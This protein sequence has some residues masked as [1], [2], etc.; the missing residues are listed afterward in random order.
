MAEY[1]GIE[2]GM[3]FNSY[4]LPQIEVTTRKDRKMLIRSMRTLIKSRPDISNSHIH[5]C[6]PR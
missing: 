5:I 2:W 3:H 1:A 6:Y 4:A